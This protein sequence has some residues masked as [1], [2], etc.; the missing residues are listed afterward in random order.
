LAPPVFTLL[1]LADAL[2]SGQKSPVRG[3]RI[4]QNSAIVM[5]RLSLPAR[6]LRGRPAS[7]RTFADAAGCLLRKRLIWRALSVMRPAIP[8]VEPI[9]LPAL[10]E[11]GSELGPLAQGKPR[12]GLGLLVSKRTVAAAASMLIRWSPGQHRLGVALV[13]AARLRLLTRVS[14]PLSSSKSSAS[15]TS[16]T[17]PSCS[18]STIV[19]VRR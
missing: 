19:T 9:F 2:L 7:L 12:Y 5:S 11:P 15:F 14:E 16:I 4:R 10:R 17:P 6:S 3:A 18:A 1:P 13:Q 8:G